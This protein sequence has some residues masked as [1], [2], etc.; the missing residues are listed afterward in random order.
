[1]SKLP[2]PK[3]VT[4]LVNQEL[5]EKALEAGATD[6]QAQI[7]SRRV[8]PKG[9]DINGFMNPSLSNIPPVGKMKD[10]RKAG[11]RIA[12][13]IIEGEQICLACDFDVDGISSA[14]VMAKAIIDL[15]G[16]SQHKV[17]IC[18]SNRMTEG[19]GLND[20]VIERILAK[21]P[22]P[23]LIITADQ[24]SANEPQIKKYIEETKKIS[25]RRKSAKRTIDRVGD[26]VVSDHHE[27]PTSGNPPSAYAFVNPQR[28]D[29]DYPDKTIC[30]CTVAMFM[31]ASVRQALIK[32]GYLTEDAPTIKPLMAFATA[33]TIADCVNMA[34]QI[35]RAIVQH[36]LN[37]INNETLPAWKAMKQ[38][39]IKDP[40][41]PVTAES[42]AFGLG[43]MINACSR[44]GGDGLNAVRYYLADS[45]ADAQ[46]YLSF[47]E[48]DNVKRKGI[49]KRLVDEAV[50][51]SIELLEKG[52]FSLVIPIKN[53]HHGIHGIAASRIV[54]RFGRPTIILSPK[55][56]HK[57]IV[58]KEEAEQLIGQK[59]VLNQIEERYDIPR[60]FSFISHEIKT[61]KNKKKEYVFYKETITVMSG[62]GRSVDG[63]GADQR[64]ELNLLQCMI[65]AN[66]KHD[67]FLGFGGHHMAAGMGLVSENV[68]KLRNGMEEAVR[69][70][71]DES[72]LYPKIWSDGE[73]PVG[74]EIN[75]AFVEEISGLEPYGRQFDYPTFTIEAEVE[76]LDIKGSNEDT[77]IFQLNYNGEHYKGVWFKYILSSA[78][79]YIRVGC[80]YRFVVAP[81][82]N[83]YN[84]SRTVQ[85]MIS[86]AEEL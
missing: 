30:G 64:G 48:T 68:M 75:D 5:Y 26:V 51:K 19:Y 23:S 31:M 78:S 54:E 42:I 63:L 69:S 15:F 57:E 61:G 56:T 58:T 76:R 29:D 77:G 49:E 72:E 9:T 38:L 50:E 37:E 28:K 71:I 27:I 43:P 81:K 3:I 79:E 60:S 70:K 21:D 7:I 55:A 83:Y 18:I 32:K 25:K 33:A 66:E 47:L 52:F 39:C 67:I 8:L 84:N 36:G 53:G 6:L 4:R 73:L 12:D 1:M 86:Y 22:I 80:K 11:N 45:D 46:R 62:S 41:Q 59:I 40:L 82:F 24:G 74:C 44:T 17:D 20:Q 85:L 2:E 35:N 13:A 10:I 65:D 14:A 34:S 16:Y